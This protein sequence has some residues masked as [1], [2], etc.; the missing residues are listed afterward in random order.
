MHVTIKMSD[1]APRMRDLYFKRTGLKRYILPIMEHSDKNK[2][3]REKSGKIFLFVV[4]DRFV[5]TPNSSTFG[6]S[7][8]LFPTDSCILFYN[9]SSPDKYTTISHIQKKLC[10]YAVKLN[11][12]CTQYSNTT[13][14]YI[15]LYNVIPWQ[16]ALLRNLKFIDAALRSICWCNFRKRLTAQK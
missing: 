6:I 14:K 12:A 16:L 5:D 11:S 1:Y 9:T 13:Q 2:A 7:A 8:S 10:L 3:I 4:M 15:F